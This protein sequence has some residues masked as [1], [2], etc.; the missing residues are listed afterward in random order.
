MSAVEKTDDH[1]TTWHGVTKETAGGFTKAAY[2]TEEEI[3]GIL[4]RVTEGCPMTLACREFGTS[5]T[6]FH[7]RCRREPELEQRRLQA[8]AEGREQYQE[9]L[10][11]EAFHQAFVEKNYKAL[12]DQML[13]HLPEAQTLGIAKHLHAKLDPE[14]LRAMAARQL[15]ELNDEELAQVIALMERGK[16]GEKDGKKKAALELVEGDVLEA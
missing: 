8:L 1:R 12:R 4:E 13:M 3:E 10:R 15:G 7:R 6:Q 5:T 9:L 2:L 16:T 14:E 11:N